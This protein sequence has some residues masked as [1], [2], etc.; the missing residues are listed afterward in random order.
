MT[1][2]N[3]SNEMRIVPEQ[4]GYDDNN[5]PVFHRIAYCDNCK[6]R[7]DLDGKPIEEVLP[8]QQIEE[9][10]IAADPPLTEIKETDDLQT[11][12]VK[13]ELAKMGAPSDKKSNTF[14]VVMMIFAIVISLGIGM[15]PVTIILFIILLIMLGYF[16]KESKRK[17]YEN[18]AS[19]KKRVNVCPR[20]KSDN[21]EMH[22]VVTGGYTSH[23]KTTLS[24]N[25]NPLRPFTHTNVNEGSDYTSNSYGNKC[26]CLNCGNV[27][28][29][30]EVHYI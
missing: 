21:I 13:E 2:P 22:M 5:L 15:I 19:G 6:K 20:C 4:V 26:H 17:E 12:L 30:P 1:C 11:R 10:E 3:C 29:F 16:G 24:K 28:T 9:T 18:I 27:F 14:G 23:G 25:I 8:I 7:N